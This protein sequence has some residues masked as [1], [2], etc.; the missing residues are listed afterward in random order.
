MT[1]SDTARQMARIAARAAYDKLGENIVALDVS[2]QLVITEV[3]LIVS[4][5]NERQ[6]NAVVEGVEDQ[7]REA[8]FKPVRREGAREGR[9]TLLDYLDIVVHVFHSEEREFYALEKL[10][11]DC[12]RIE[13]DLP[14][15]P[16]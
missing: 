10:W 11:K 6:V 13:L 9:W 1:A 7:L 5:S 2:E 4:A 14:A 12:P 8:G 3:F 16:E 15:A